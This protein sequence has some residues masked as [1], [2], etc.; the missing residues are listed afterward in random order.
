M[1]FYVIFCTGNNVLYV[2]LYRYIYFLYIICLFVSYVYVSI[3]SIESMEYSSV[4]TL[5]FSLLNIGCDFNI[6]LLFF[7]NPL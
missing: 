6:N 3:E 7:M 1:F 4:N 5:C 2:L